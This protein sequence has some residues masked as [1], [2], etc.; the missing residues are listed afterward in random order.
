MG[1]LTGQVALVTGGGRGVGRGIARALAAEGAAV[2][3]D[4]VYRDESGV[5]AAEATAREIEA[6]GGKALALYEDVT[7]AD[8]ARAMVDAT[9]KQFGRIDIL[10]T[11]AGNAVRGPLHELTEQQWDSVI[12]LHVRGHFLSCKMALPYMLKQN[13]GRILTV[14]SRGA[15]FQVPASKRDSRDVRKPPS[16]AY[17]AAKAA[18][19]GLTTT[20]A[21]EL[22]ETG[23]TVNCLMP[24]ATTQLFPESKPRMVGGV[25]ASESLDPDDIAPAAVYLCT[26]QAGDISGK[27]MYASGGDVLFYGDQ[28]DARGSRMIRKHGR[29]TIDE[30]ANVVPSLLG[31]PNV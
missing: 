31:I 28:L 18:I 24:S 10:V 30:L 1:Y 17:S 27:F 16:T 23:I 8:G 25:P 19:M 7:S 22:W 6:A 21:V 26:P 11:C 12:N 14:G 29:W 13:S 9:V 3:I 5:G 4:D 2:A 20:L 15:F